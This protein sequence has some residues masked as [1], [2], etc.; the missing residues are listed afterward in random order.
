MERRF[1]RR[2][3]APISVGDELDVKIETVGSKGDGVARVKGF[4]IFV[5]GTK[6]GDEVKIRVNKV[7]NKVSFAEVITKNSS[8]ETSEEQYETQEE[9]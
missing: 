2:S 6:Q 4:V 1:G 8:Q 7:L 5:P 9:V 3:F